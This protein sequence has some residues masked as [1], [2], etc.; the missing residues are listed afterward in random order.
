LLIFPG[1][2]SGETFTPKAL[3]CLYNVFSIKDTI[4]KKEARDL[5]ALTG[6]TITQVSY[7]VTFFCTFVV[8]MIGRKRIVD[9]LVFSRLENFSLARELGSGKLSN[10]LMGSALLIHL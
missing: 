6:A 8:C 5:S 3:K 4:T 10:C 1:K 7:I 2:K 9:S